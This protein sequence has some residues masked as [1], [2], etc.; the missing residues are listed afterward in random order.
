MHPLLQSYVFKYVL[1]VRILIMV[2]HLDAGCKFQACILH[3]G[4][5]SFYVA[6][7]IFWLPSV[8]VPE[9]IISFAPGQLLLISEL[10]QKCSIYFTP[11][12]K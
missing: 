5:L 7:N 12:F 4:L 2:Q 10:S 1:T 6:T 8:P 9:K 3:V 11:P